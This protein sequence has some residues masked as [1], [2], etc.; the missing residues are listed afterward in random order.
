MNITLI[1]V[2]SIPNDMSATND[3]IIYAAISLACASTAVAVPN[4]HKKRK[5]VDFG[6]G[7]CCSDETSLALLGV[8][9]A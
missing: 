6:F 9:K 5:N 1:S 7:N 2:S 3:D 4:M 8:L